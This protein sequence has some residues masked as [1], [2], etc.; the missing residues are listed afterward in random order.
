MECSAHKKVTIDFET[1]TM[2]SRHR[3][4]NAEYEEAQTEVW[5]RAQLKEKEEKNL[6]WQ[7]YEELQRRRGNPSERRLVQELYHLYVR[8]WGSPQ[9]LTCGLHGAYIPNSIVLFERV[10]LTCLERGIF[11]ISPFSPSRQQLCFK[12]ATD[13]RLLFGEA[14]QLIILQPLTI[15]HPQNTHFAVTLGMANLK[16]KNRRD[17]RLL[18]NAL[19]I[20]D[21]FR[22]ISQKTLRIRGHTY[23]FRVLFTGDWNSLRYVFAIPPPGGVNEQALVCL[24]C[25]C[26][27]AFLKTAWR[28][29]PFAAIS[30]SRANFRNESLLANCAPSSVVYCAMHCVTRLLVLL[31][32]LLHG[33]APELDRPQLEQL[34]RRYS[35]RWMERGARNQPHKNIRPQNAKKLWKRRI[36][37]QVPS[38]FVG[39]N[40]GSIKT[41]LPWP[42]DLRL[43]LHDAPRTVRLVMHAATR[44]FEFVYTPWPS[45]QAFRVVWQARTV[46]VAFLAAHDCPQ[47]PA[48]HYCLNH[49]LQFAAEFNTAYGMLGEAIE[50]QH[51]VERQLARRTAT[52]SVTGSGLIVSPQ[53]ILAHEQCRREVEVDLPRPSDAPPAELQDI[54]PFPPDFLLEQLPLHVHW[55]PMRE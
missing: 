51:R 31:L 19:S 5:Q 16:E 37:E 43:Q 34:L 26:N 53:E 21:L 20:D 23:T 38:Y 9:A 3:A 22:H 14:N 55:K 18:F 52:Q 8:K 35:P 54:S 30:S 7:Q 24:S 47:T 33:L 10:V 48:A 44:F 27:R 39:C 49:L 17:L 42:H 41:D 36:L 13:G 28:R 32:A 46:I 29:T 4:S 12:L 15:H 2:T 50:A 45:D 40:N 11:H 6:S 25:S 1:S